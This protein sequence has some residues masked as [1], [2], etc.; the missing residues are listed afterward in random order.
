ME[1]IVETIPYDRVKD[2]DMVRPFFGDKKVIM[3]DI[4]TTGL[5]PLKSFTYIIGVN[6]FTGNEWQIIQLFNDDGT[7]EPEMIR[8]FQEMLLDADVLMHF[9]GDTFDIPYIQRRMQFIEHRFSISLK[10]NFNS[11][12]SF[13]LLKNI[14]PY[15]F[16]LGLPNLKQ[17]T[18]ERY[19]GLDRI[20]MYNGGQ[21]I[22]V[23]LGY[24]A[25]GDKRSRELVLQHN[26]DDM[27]GMIYLTSMLSID[28]MERGDFEVTDL[29]TA[30]VHGGKGLELI[31]SGKLEHPVIH[32]VCNFMDGMQLDAE[33]DKFTLKLPVYSG[34]LNYYYGSTIKD[35]CSQAEGYFAPCPLEGIEKLP[36]Y[37]ESPKSRQSYI[38][39]SDSFLGE[40]TF[41]KEYSRKIIRDIMH[42]KRK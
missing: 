4:E 29:S 31:I 28:L 20:D 33:R 36:L 26:R 34:I 21:L 6:I 1:K 7:S 32:P 22:D 40:K 14:R 23:Y 10:D 11:L 8:V 42:F 24:L 25:A 27:E 37:R 16:A 18:I 41:V 39:L 3:F 5:S 15:K 35:G 12:E 17:K 30:S 19:I 38:M 9:N 2:I 13:D